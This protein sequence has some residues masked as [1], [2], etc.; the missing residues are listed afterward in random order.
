MVEQIP[1]QNSALL[2]MNAVADTSRASSNRSSSLIDLLAKEDPE[3]ASALKKKMEEA[4]S[5]I[6]QL[7]SR[8]VDFNEQRKAAAQQKIQRIKAQLESLRLLASVNPEAAARRAAQPSRELAAAVKEY[9]A[10]GGGAAGAVGSMVSAGQPAAN[11]GAEAPNAQ[12][13]GADAAAPVAAAAAGIDAGAAGSDDAGKPVGAESDKQSPVGA[14]VEDAVEGEDD[15][16]SDIF[17]D[18]G[19]QTVRERVL[20]LSASMGQ[21]FAETRGKQEFMSLVRDV[22]NQL[23]AILE[24]AKRQLERED[25]DAADK[26]ISS[27]EK[28]LQDV[29]GALN[30]MIP[31][32]TAGALAGVNILA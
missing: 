9:A 26:D 32:I 1:S 4:D 29:D 17:N 13:T 23:K 16:A 19:G 11:T 24:T 15:D 2:L 27:A 18:D 14:A 28:A 12:T 30:Q 5:L 7:K 10:A 6:Q 22:K 25:N 3:K 8:K 20:E 21:R 31:T